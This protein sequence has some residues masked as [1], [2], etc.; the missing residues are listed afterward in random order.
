MPPILNRVKGTA[1][2]M[3]YFAMGKLFRG[4]VHEKSF[5]LN[6]ASSF[7]VR[8]RILSREVGYLF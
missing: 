2:D 4:K 5:S 3:R 8:I 1:T 6:M 7:Q